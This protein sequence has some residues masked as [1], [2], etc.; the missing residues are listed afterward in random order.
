V[1]ENTFDALE[2]RKPDHVEDADWHRAINDGRQFLAGWGETAERLGWTADDLF[3]LPP[4][5][6]NP[7]PNYRRLSRYDLTGLVWMLRGRFVVGMAANSASVVTPNGGHLTF[8][9]LAGSD[10]VDIIDTV[11][12]P[13]LRAGRVRGEGRRVRLHRLHQMPY[14]RHLKRA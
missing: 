5:P 7:A 12:L 8:Y 2:R 1:L 11:A 6:E 4:I 9:R 3:G 10:T 13:P 14:G